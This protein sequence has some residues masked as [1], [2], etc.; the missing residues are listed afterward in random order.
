MPLRL[1]G[2]VEQGLSYDCDY[3]PTYRHGVDA[4][5]RY[6]ERHFDEIETD[7]SEGWRAATPASNGSA[8]SRR[9]ATPGTG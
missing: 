6:P 9:R 8:P 5:V 1:S 4:Y 3:V 2:A 7:L